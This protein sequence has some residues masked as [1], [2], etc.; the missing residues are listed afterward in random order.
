GRGR[1]ATVSGDSLI[2]ARSTRTMDARLPP[3]V[4]KSGMMGF[5]AI[6]ECRARDALHRWRQMSNGKAGMLIIRESSN[7]KPAIGN[8]R[9]V[10]IGDAA[11]CIHDFSR[12][13]HEHSAPSCERA[14]RTAHNKI[15]LAVGIPIH[16][17][18]IGAC[19]GAQWEE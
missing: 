1:D 15:I 7:R 16:D 19:S 4:P 18:D 17:S 3:T 6:H 2:D 5:G 13:H 12:I 9:T 8:G 10:A 14:A 11:C